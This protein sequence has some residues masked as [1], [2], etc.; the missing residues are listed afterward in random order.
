MNEVMLCAISNTNSGDC[1]E[2]CAFCTQSV[3]YNSKIDSFEF[4]DK[5]EVLK[6]AK[7]ASALG[8]LG[9]CLVT[10]GKEL[11]EAKLSYII[12]CAELINKEALGL[13]I[14]ACNGMASKEALRELKK[15]GVYA[16][17]HNLET[18]REHY[19]NICTT[20]EWD[21]R[22]QTCLNV[23]EVGLEL[24]SG[25]IFGVGESDNDRIS[26]FE[27]LKELNPKTSPINFYYPNDALP[28]PK[29]TVSKEEALS[30]IKMANEALP[31]T[32][33]MAAGGR[34]LVFDSM[35]EAVNAGFGSVVIGD[36]LTAKGESVRCDIEDMK[37]HGIKPVTKC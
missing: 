27:A 12:E 2:D 19:P 20:M 29:E 10:S 35:S 14:I 30:I 31:E 24:C 15:A 3:Y 37:K 16:Y 13:H 7:V 18:S 6:E 1:A 5:H 36:Y 32:V 33:F 22:F 11:N 25:G 34:N 23:K 9:F 8:A 28:L 17:N 4:K 21:E 26:Y